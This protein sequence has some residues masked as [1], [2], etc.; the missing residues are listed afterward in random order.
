MK[1]VQSRLWVISKEKGMLGLL[2][3]TRG[4]LNADGEI[5]DEKD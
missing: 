2:K 4:G 1:K 5:T 3:F